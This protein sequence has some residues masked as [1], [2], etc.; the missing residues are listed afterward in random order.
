MLAQLFKL[1]HQRQKTERLSNV[2]LKSENYS[3]ILISSMTVSFARYDASK[4]DQQDVIRHDKCDLCRNTLFLE[5]KRV[6]GDGYFLEPKPK[7]DFD[8]VKEICLHFAV[9]NG[10]TYLL[11][12]NKSEAEGQKKRRLDV[13]NL[14]CLFVCFCFVQMALCSSL[15]TRNSKADILWQPSFKTN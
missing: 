14:M 7:A 3:K 15:I 2:A 6:L 13:D 10:K 9:I 12:E 5:Q 11:A 8:A 4:T 1:A